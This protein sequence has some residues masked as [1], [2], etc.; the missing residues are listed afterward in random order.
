MKTGNFMDHLKFWMSYSIEFPDRSLQLGRQTSNLSFN[1][2]FVNR[3]SKRF[4]F[5]LFG[6]KR[7]ELRVY[8]WPAVRIN[9]EKVGESP[10]Y[11]RSLVHTP[12]DNSI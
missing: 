1:Q 9:P 7:E 6:T 2:G 8:S 4:F 3:N 5:P 12:G 10:A 11:C